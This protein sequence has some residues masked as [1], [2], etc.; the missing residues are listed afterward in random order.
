MHIYNV[1]YRFW[2]GK[3]N[4]TC[5]KNIEHGQKNWACSKHF[6]HGQNV[7]ELADGMGITHKKLGTLENIRVIIPDRTQHA[8]RKC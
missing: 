2:Q 1:K 7:F 5:S 3:K 8:Y 6:E 4:W